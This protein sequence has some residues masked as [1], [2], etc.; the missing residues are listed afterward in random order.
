MPREEL[1]AFGNTPRNV[2]NMPDGY[3]VE[4]TNA[5]QKDLD[6]LEPYRERAVKEIL[7]LE[8]DPLKGHPLHGRLRRYRALEFSLPGGVC[9]AVYE[10]INSQKVC[11]VFAVGYHESRYEIATR[12][13]RGLKQKR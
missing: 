1:G 11:L 3:R 2:R 6:G 9:R 7:E 10:V 5:A 8:K 13:S 4:A 12:R